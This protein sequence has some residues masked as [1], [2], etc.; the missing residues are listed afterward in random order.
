MLENITSL[1]SEIWPSASF[2]AKG[3]IIT[4]QYSATSVFLGLIIGIFIAMCKISSNIIV[5]N[6][7]NF[8]TSIF[9]GTPLLIQLS[10]IYFAIPSLMNI[11]ISVFAGGIIAF[12]LN[13]GAYVSEIIRA[14][15]LSIDTGQ[16]EAAKVLNVPKFYIYKDIIIPQAVRNILPSLVNELIDLVKESSLISILGEMDLMHRAQLVSAET[17]KYFMPMCIA[18]ACYYCIVMLLSYLAKVLERKLAI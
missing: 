10:I 18:A 12:S 15:I 4:L 14:G 3:V 13:S 9:R 8:Y 2:I 11:K 7:A 17:Y 6:L 1:G 5:S 16:F